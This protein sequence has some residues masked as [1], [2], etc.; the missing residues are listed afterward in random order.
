VIE[1]TG[2]SLSQQTDLL[3]DKANHISNSISKSND[4]FTDRLYNESEG[5]MLKIVKSMAMDD[6]SV[7]AML[8][9]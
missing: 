5:H 8:C 3:R 9:D 6:I 4:T 1:L 7:E 2:K